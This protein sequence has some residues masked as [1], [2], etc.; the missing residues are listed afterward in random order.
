MSWDPDLYH[1]F[2]TE[3]LRP[4]ADLLAWIPLVAPATIVDLGCGAGESTALLAGRWPDAD[5]TALDNSP[6][7]LARAR[8]CGVAARWVE[9]DLT[10]WTP[11]TAPALIYSNA[12]FHWL[13][14][15]ER[16][17]ARLMGLLA[18]GGVLAAQMPLNHAAP[19]HRCVAETIAAGPW[20]ERL[21]PLWRS[22][23][24]A[25]PEAYRD[26]L[27]GR[28]ETLEIWETAYHH[29]LDG[30]NPVAEWVRGTTLSPLLAVLDPGDADVFFADCAGRLARAY[31]P[32]ADGTTV[33]PFRRLF[34]I[35][36]APDA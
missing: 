31:P 20:R 18:P 28:T 29:V 24:V 26:W 11:P 2:A 17:F 9:A 16:L 13:D 32:R 35:A 36:Q 1:R 5:I 15:H 8:A 30:D 7:M 33:L 25:E 21:T 23:P 19:S 34:L 6:R 14:D 12:V 22:R 4:S 10:E 3:R 27:Q